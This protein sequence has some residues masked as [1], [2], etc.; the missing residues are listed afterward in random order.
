[1]RQ[2]REQIRE[3]ERATTAA[4]RCYLAAW[5]SITLCET[6]RD[7]EIAELRRRIGVVENT[8]D[9]RIAQLRAEQAAAARAIRDQPGHTAGDV[10]NLLEITPKQARQLLALARTE[11]PQ[12]SAAHPR[13]AIAV[14]DREDPSDEPGVPQ[15][16][17]ER[18]ARTNG[19][20]EG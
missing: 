13:T 4:V 17:S 2:R 18:P 6:E 12:P 20:G 8:A 19:G 7:D 9:A 11:Q 3:R 14:S 16:N 1:M 10:A 5:Q 15:Q